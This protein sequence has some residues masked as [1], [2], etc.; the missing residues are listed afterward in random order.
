MDRQR[1]PVEGA[2]DDRFSDVVASGS[3]PWLQEVRRGS[4]V[5]KAVTLSVLFR[6]APAILEG[7]QSGAFACPDSFENTDGSAPDFSAV[8]LHSHLARSM[9]LLLPVEALR[10]SLREVGFPRAVEEDQRSE[11]EVYKQE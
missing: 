7:L 9:I 3:L 1:Q 5:A 8:V 6:A 11:V 2:T 10:E 4:G